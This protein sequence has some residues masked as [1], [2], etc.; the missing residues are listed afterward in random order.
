M[1]GRAS[2]ALLPLLPLLLILSSDFW[3]YADA[4]ARANR[5]RPVVFSA[6][7]FIVDTPEA[8][9][10]AS[11]LLWIVFVPLYVSSRNK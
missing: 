9:F 6:G 5:G 8:W 2:S 11:L 7:N 3:L 1:H 4:K 10:L